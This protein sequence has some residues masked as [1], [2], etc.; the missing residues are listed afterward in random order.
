MRFSLYQ[1]LFGWLFLHLALLMAVAAAL[2]GGI[3]LKGSN[4]LLPTSFFSGNIENSFRTISAHCQYTSVRQWD[5]IL[6]QYDRSPALS[7][8][9]YPLDDPAF[10]L[11]APVVPA[12]L[13]A[14]A[15]RL[16][17][18]PFTLC[19]DPSI[20][21][22]LRQDG[23]Q[24]YDR[25][26]PPGGGYPDFGMAQV[27]TQG[28]DAG[29]P[30]TPKALFMRTADP[31]R[32][33]LGMPL[34]IPDENNKLH[35]VLLAAASDSVFGHGMYFD[36]QPVLG[37]LGAGLLVSCLW[38]WPFVRHMTRPL[39]RMESVTAKIVADDP[40]VQA[41]LHANK[42]L[43]SIRPGRSDEIGRLASSINAMARRMHSALV[44][45]RRF[46]SHIAHEINSPLARAQIGLAL[47]EE[48]AGEAEKEKL[49]E[50]LAEVER[51]SAMTVDILTFLREE[52]EPHPV[53]F[54]PVELHAFLSELIEFEIPPE[55][56]VC[57]N[58]P[59]D[60]T[61]SVPRRYLHRAV[62]A[63]F[64]NIP[65]RA[66]H[67]GCL[68]IRAAEEAEFVRIVI[69]L[70]EPGCSGRL[71]CA[72]TR[73]FFEHHAAVDSGNSGPGLSIVDYCIDVCRG[74]VRFFN[75]DPSGRIAEIRLPKRV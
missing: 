64:H 27:D 63:I 23:E 29:I 4:G 35:Y 9:I 40:A 12:R 41:D 62:R 49:G 70:K 45:Q 18:H 73:P 52:S 32:Y 28:L 10:P 71:S 17:R 14:A 20:A 44:Q 19:P 6:E 25:T 1:K 43:F 37:L 74:G 38:W 7:F 53:R 46:I 34:F 75:D 60:L 58:A 66:V 3:L 59:E 72:S 22:A 2:V 69:A 8:V 13:A 65:D 30:L 51:L 33:W 36:L 42:N 50:V 5:E 68:E 16:P 21:L 55:G 61:L 31:A 26:R 67:E 48:Q 24:F 39:V 54:E 11:P 56:A 15:A 57:L 47:M